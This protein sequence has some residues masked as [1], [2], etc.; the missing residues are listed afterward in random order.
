VAG[1]LA[2]TGTPVDRR[3]HF[4]CHLTPIRLIG[5]ALLPAARLRPPMRW[6]DAGSRTR[7]GSTSAALTPDYVWGAVRLDLRHD[8]AARTV[9]IDILQALHGERL[10]LPARERYPIRACRWAGIAGSRTRRQP[11]RRHYSCS[12]HVCVINK[13]L[14]RDRAEAC[15]VGPCFQILQST[16]TAIS[17]DHKSLK[18]RRRGFV[19][20]PSPSASLPVGD[21]LFHCVHRGRK[22]AECGPSWRIVR[23]TRPA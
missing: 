3:G 5:R 14:A 7:T 19:Y 11:S 21:I 18:R 10:S 23:S 13:W 12:H 16:S 1:V 17:V 15:G 8:E 22:P 20:R 2:K 4:Q 9:T 6:S